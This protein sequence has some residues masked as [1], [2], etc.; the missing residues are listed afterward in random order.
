MTCRLG[1]RNASGRAQR[2]G[3]TVRLAVASWLRSSE[4]QPPGLC[5]YTWSF[6]RVKEVVLQ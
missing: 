2:P 6:Q 4:A 5:A 1:S 3:W